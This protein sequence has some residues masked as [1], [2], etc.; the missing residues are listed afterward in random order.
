[1]S[2]PST[3]SRR[4]LARTISEPQSSNSLSPVSTDPYS[5]TGYEPRLSAEAGND[6]DEKQEDSIEEVA[7]QDDLDVL[8]NPDLSGESSSKKNQRPDT[9]LDKILKSIVEIVQS[10][11]QGTQTT[12]ES[13]GKCSRPVV[14]VLE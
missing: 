1:M 5:S 12:L 7:E 13:I 2:F 9:H 10:S 14:W 11:T 6:S 4:L 3:R 8:L